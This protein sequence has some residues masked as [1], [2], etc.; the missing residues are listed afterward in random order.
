MPFP[1]SCVIWQ[2][3]KGLHFQLYG[4]C[5]VEKCM[6]FYNKVIGLT[7]AKQLIWQDLEVDWESNLVYLHQGG[8]KA[9]NISYLPA[10]SA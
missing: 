8:E 9:L 4:I 1:S 5:N 6:H 2:S 3:L 7:Q 10:G